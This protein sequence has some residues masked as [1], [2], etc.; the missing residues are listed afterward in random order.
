M[1]TSL[2]EALGSPTLVRHMAA[3]PRDAWC[4]AVSGLQ[5]Q[6]LSGPEGA[7]V[8]SP[9]APTPVE[10]GQIGTLR[11]VV[12]LL[13]GVDPDETVVVAGG[14]QAMARPAGEAASEERWWSGRSSCRWSSIRGTTQR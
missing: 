6:V 9:A 1:K 3:I 10:L 8:R 5:V 7:I 13:M 14:G 2:W 4:T 11:R 12:R